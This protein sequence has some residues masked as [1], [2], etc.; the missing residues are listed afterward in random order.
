MPPTDQQLDELFRHR[1]RHAKPLRTLAQ[2][3]KFQTDNGR[4]LY[5]AIPIYPG[6]KPSPHIVWESVADFVNY[7]RRI[8]GTHPTMTRYFSSGLVKEE[9]PGH[10]GNTIDDMI[11]LYDRGWNEGLDTVKHYIDEAITAATTAAIETEDLVRDVHGA[12]I[13]IPAFLRGEPENMYEFHDTVKEMLFLEVDLDWFFSSSSSSTNYLYRG[14][15]VMSA[16]MALQRLGVVVNLYAREVSRSVTHVSKSHR[17]PHSCTIKLMGPGKIE[18]LSETMLAVA[19]PDFNMPLFYL[20][21]CMAWGCQPGYGICEQDR[22]SSEFI[23]KPGSGKVVIPGVF[24][25]ALDD[26]DTIDW[27]NLWASPNAAVQM[28]KVMLKCAAPRKY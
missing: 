21:Q 3:E 15:A 9:R 23:P 20:A 4:G 16:V 13:D 28:V 25:F 8:P 1:G 10:C 22:S 7:V 19:H 26:D 17:A 5:D 11:A 2:Y 27:Q 18:N 12:I 14:I 6:V 24:N